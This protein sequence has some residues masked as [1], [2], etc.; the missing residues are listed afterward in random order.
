MCLSFTMDENDQENNRFYCEH[1]GEKISKT[2][3]YLHKRLYYS[4]ATRIW[5]KATDSDDA[6]QICK[7]DDEFKFSDTE[8]I[9]S[10]EGM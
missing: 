6:V 4:T 8:S 3:Y 9:T 5:Q 10:H 1:C 7:V 2:L